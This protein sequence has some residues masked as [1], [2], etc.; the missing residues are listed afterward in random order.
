MF[1]YYVI[2]H[3]IYLLRHASQKK[4]MGN[5]N[6]L[7]TEQRGAIFYC[8]QR[9]DSYKKI[10]ETVGCGKTTVFDTLKRY[11]ET[12]SMDSKC[13]SERS[14]LINNNQIKRLKRLVTNKKTQ[15]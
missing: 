8:R 15:N 5:K 12:G 9:G 1:A 4:K 6:E 14:Y 2:N 10:S 7:T 13:R 11:N 3:L